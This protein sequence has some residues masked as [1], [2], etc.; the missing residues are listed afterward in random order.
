VGAI[1]GSEVRQFLVAPGMGS[2]LNSTDLISDGS[3][4]LI[5]N[6]VYAG[7][8]SPF[9][10]LDA[11][12][13][14]VYYLTDGMGSG[15]ATHNYDV[16]NIASLLPYRAEEVVPEDS[17]TQRDRPQVAAINSANRNYW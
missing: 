2:G 17:Y 8:A 15:V 4:N 3:G 14:P 6:Y 7:G 13:N 5:S 10:M 9:M 16:F 11:N 12:G 1:E